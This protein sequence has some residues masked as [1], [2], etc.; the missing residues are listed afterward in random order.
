MM[1]IVKTSKGALAG[2]Q[3][4]PFAGIALRQFELRRARAAMLSA[5]RIVDSITG[6][7]H[8]ARGICSKLLAVSGAVVDACIASAERVADVLI[9]WVDLTLQ[10]HG[11]HG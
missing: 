1:S 4:E 8:A 11:R 10:R 9:A 5:E 2:I 3:P 7:S 6:A